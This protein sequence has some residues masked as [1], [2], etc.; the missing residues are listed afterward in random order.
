MPEE[1]CDG[2]QPQVK[3]PAGRFSSRPAEQPPHYTADLD[4]QVCCWQSANLSGGKFLA[5]DAVQ[6]LSGRL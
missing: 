5:E 6:A 4:L 1:S 3:P 2:S